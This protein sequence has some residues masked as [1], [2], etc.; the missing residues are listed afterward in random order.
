MTVGQGLRNSG[1]TCFL[2]ATIQCLGA[3]DEVNPAHFLTNKPTITQDKL[4][5]CIRELQQP[6]TAY[7]PAPL[8][9]QIPHLICY[10]KG[11]PADAHELLIDLTDIPRP[12]GLN[13]PMFPL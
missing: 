10:R 2:N 8:I 9:Q 5:T 6:G 1:N 11:D 7:M 4:M 13:S 12:N 3:I